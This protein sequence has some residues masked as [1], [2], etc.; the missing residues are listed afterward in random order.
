[1]KISLRAL[2][3]RGRKQAFTLIELLVVIAIIAILAAILFPVFA[4][5]R[6]KARQTACVSNEKQISLGMLMYEQDYDGY[7]PS[8]TFF[9][10]ITYESG[11]WLNTMMLVCPYL[12]AP[13]VWA[14]PSNPY[15]QKAMNYGTTNFAFASYAL[16]MQ[17]FDS[18]YYGAPHTE[19]FIQEP[20]SKIML[21]EAVAYANGSAAPPNGNG[22]GW[23]SLGWSYWTGTT[24]DGWQTEGF[25]H[26]TGT[27]NVAYCDGHVK[28][29]RPENTAGAN[30]QINGWGIFTDNN[31][32]SCSGEWLS[33]GL[34]C[35]NY[36]PG[37]TQ[38]LQLLTNKWAH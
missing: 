12:K 11:Q 27:M 5:V 22:A 14:C 23:D 13:N 32:G 34:N 21:G 10:G 7:F 3:N 24:A 36:S 29:V 31:G 18:V 15:S 38:N 6:E 20:S 25:C 19:A 1:M 9:A 30:G 8:D 26:N 33:G 2:E 4:K 35:D 37:A 17:L 28:A 16:N